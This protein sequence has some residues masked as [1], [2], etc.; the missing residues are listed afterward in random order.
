V[1]TE[2]YCGLRKLQL[3]RNVVNSNC[4]ASMLVCDYDLD[5][6]RVALGVFWHFAHYNNYNVSTQS[7]FC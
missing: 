2:G 6:S 5:R 4:L 7:T 3:V 1:T